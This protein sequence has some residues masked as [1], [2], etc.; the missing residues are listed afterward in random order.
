MCKYIIQEGILRYYYK[1]K[2]VNTRFKLN[3]I[4]NI[5]IVLIVNSLFQSFNENKKL[6][7]KQYVIL[8][9]YLTNISKGQVYDV[10]NKMYSNQN[11]VH[12]YIFVINIL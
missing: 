7:N 6:Y 8:Q 5:I 2:Y 4:N 3:F 12:R 11:M 9:L 1:L 10:F